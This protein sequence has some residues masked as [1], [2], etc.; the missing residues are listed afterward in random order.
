MTPETAHAAGIRDLVLRSYA[1]FNARDMETYGS[2]LH[3]DVAVDVDGVSLRGR[4]AVLSF[5][6]SMLGS[7]PD[8]GV[9]PVRVVAQTGTTIV[10]ELRL[11]NPVAPPVADEPGWKLDGLICEIFEVRDGQI[12]SIRS[13]HAAHS[14]DR[15]LVGEVPSR[16]EAA[17]MAAEEA[18]VRRIATSVARGAPQ[19]EIVTAVDHALAGT[20]GAALTALLRFEDDGRVTTVA[21][22]AHRR[23]LADLGGPSTAAPVLDGWHA[24]D[25]ARRLGPAPPVQDGPLFEQAVD[26]DLRSAIGVPIEVGSR[27][28][29]IAYVGTADGD[30]LPQPTLA[31]V[32]RFTELLAAALVNAQSRAALQE[33]AAEQS[34]LRRLA[35]LVARGAPRAEVF[36]AISREA[37]DFLATEFAALMSYEPDGGTRLVGCH[38]VPAGLAV[39]RVIP[40]GEGIAATVLATMRPARV[41]DYGDL[42]GPPADDSREVGVSSMAGAPIVVDG[43][44]WGVFMAG[45]TDGT[46][47]PRG[48]EHR[49]ARFAEMA[50]TSVSVAHARN[51][52]R[53]RVDEQA[54]LLRVADMVAR[55]VGQDE[56]FEAVA[57][58][59]SGLVE[60]T[61]S[62]L[63]RF[64]A[65]G[66]QT[67]VASWRGPVPVGTMPSIADDDAGVVATVRRTGR[68]A[69]SDDRAVE[70][71]S[72]LRA[73]G[74][75][76]S[77]GVPIFVEDRLWGVL[78]VALTDAEPSAD[79]RRDLL[80]AYT[81]SRLQQFAALISAA[82][83]NAHARGELRDVVD[84]QAGL[85]RV[86]ELVA[87]G[88]G[89]DELFE[90]V[91]RE[92]SR[93]VADEGTTLLRFEAESTF[94]VVASWHGPV[95]L[96]AVQVVA[97]DDVG[98]IAD[99][100]RTGRAARVD[101]YAV[102]DGP[103][104]ARKEFGVGSAAGV[105]IFVEDRM[106]GVL[107]VSQPDLGLP[108]G[109]EGR[110]L[111]LGA[112]RRLQQFAELVA[113]ALANAQARAEVQQL[114]DEQAALR[115]VAEL[116]ARSVSPQEVF[117]AVAAEASHL[118]GDEAM[119]LSRFDDRG[120]TVMAAHHS[121][122]PTG[123]WIPADAGSAVEQVRATGRPFRVDDYDVAGP[124]V[125]AAREFAIKA[126]VAVPITVGDRI[127][128]MLGATSMERALPPETEDRLAQF[129]EIAGAAI[130]NAE[131]HEQLIAS[132]TRVVATADETRRQLQRDVHD[133]AQQR[134]VQ[135]L[136][137]LKLALEALGDETG[138]VPDLVAESLATAERANAELGDIVRGI[139]PASLSR[140]GLRT[141]LE[142]LIADL[143]LPVDLDVAVPRLPVETETT[144]YFVVGEALTNV[145]KHARADRASVAIAVRGAT[146]AI[147]VRDDG[148]GGADPQ[149]GTGLMGLFDRVGATRG[150]LTIVSPPGEGTTL[151]ATLPIPVAP[152]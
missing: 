145:V 18:A 101:D 108:P 132:R 34:A 4:D 17:E 40:P 140:G 97:P 55:G 133:G 123:R 32:A 59:A 152:G 72:W 10:M 25:G 28:W 49:L 114:A 11:T 65:D 71:P 119:T 149:Q 6:T 147:E 136:V 21:A 129:A 37:S 52:L 151:R 68:P 51:E 120:A 128:G 121:P 118:V 27:V 62:T 115:R 87:R 9:E 63:L 107:A 35:E 67:V 95:A 150:T 77:A 43:R 102:I 20:P 2:L 112:E 98:L 69:R 14:D 57:R 74:V 113:A 81:E 143:K 48:L 16:I 138:V 92:A 148:V 78:V 8:V 122:L 83:A 146:L 79:D 66:R 24:A 116:A 3:A 96:G 106:W 89:Q 135:T 30:P 137:T 144:A 111:P 124:A 50:A 5:Q 29:G 76:A 38:N 45:T 15:T 41:D 109:P 110:G 64:D 141:G 131:A 127:W 12:A 56:L 60:D 7:I 85:L 100:I 1:A 31:R 42:H 58:E 99:V 54:A 13:Y 94:R 73:F 103:S 126:S 88:V 70:Q 22:S 53:E 47:L 117:E 86:A 130:A 23:P 82:L 125:S 142:S 39:G 75:V 36:T 26:L 46:R 134:L 84:E 90:T 93:L 105:P 33:L 44:T 61:P 19:D 139:L 91:A 80:P 104:Y